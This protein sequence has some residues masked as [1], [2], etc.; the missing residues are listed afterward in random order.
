MKRERERS[1]VRIRNLDSK[2]DIIPKENTDGNK[3]IRTS[4]IQIS[5]KN[6]FSWFSWPHSCRTLSAYHPSEVLQNLKKQSLWS[7]PWTGISPYSLPAKLVISNCVSK[8]RE[9]GQWFNAESS[10]RISHQH[11]FQLF[12]VSVLHWGKRGRHDGCWLL[13]IGN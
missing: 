9:A 1:L 3:K 7:N 12:S 13:R 6:I 10:T 11:H 2:Y 5:P 4:S 8:E